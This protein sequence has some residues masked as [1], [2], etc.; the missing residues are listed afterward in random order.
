M[1]YFPP[2]GKKSLARGYSGRLSVHSYICHTLD[3]FPYIWRIPQLSW[4]FILTLFSYSYQI[5][6]Y[7]QVSVCRLYFFA[8]T[9]S[10]ELHIQFPWNL[11]LTLFSLSYWDYQILGIKRGV[12]L[13]MRP[14]ICMSHLNFYMNHFFCTNLY[15]L[16]IYMVNNLFIMLIALI[17]NCN[18]LGVVR[19]A[20]AGVSP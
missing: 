6:G 9:L 20:G 11:V 17:L 1:L 13:S 19:G 5:W 2:L 14:S 7:R 10:G 18:R 12:C 8:Y 4:N 15:I 3:F 16:L